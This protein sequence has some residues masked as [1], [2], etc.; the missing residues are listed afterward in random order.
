MENSIKTYWLNHQFQNYFGFCWMVCVYPRVT[1][2]NSIPLYQF[3]PDL[4]FKDLETAAL[5]VNDWPLRGKCALTLLTLITA[6][7]KATG[8]VS[9][10]LTLM[11]ST[12]L[13]L[14][15]QVNFFFVCCGRDSRQRRCSHKWVFNWEQIVQFACVC[16]I[17]GYIYWQ[18][19]TENVIKIM[20]W[21]KMKYVLSLHLHPSCTV[22]S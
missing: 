5:P 20:N 11:E 22:W 1:W 4:V 7:H 10:R 19:R 13:R 3:F 6:D 2:R 16:V 18:N 17:A 21:I 15:R 14:K 9:P 12:V 8:A